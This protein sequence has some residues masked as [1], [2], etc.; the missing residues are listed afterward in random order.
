VERHAP[1]ARPATTALFQAFPQEGARHLAQ[2]PPIVAL[3]A[4]KSY[5]VVVKT[6][7]S[8]AQIGARVAE[9]RKARGL[10]QEDLMDALEV[11]NKAQVSRLEA[12][13]RKIS[14]A[15]LRRIAEFLNVPLDALVYPDLFSVSYRAENR[16]VENTADMQWF[17]DFRRRYRLFIGA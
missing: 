14:V 2:R 3:F 12:G 13:E 8:P 9:L 4:T 6:M 16:D 10:R 5:T 7:Q 11:T 15:E 1:L 17:R